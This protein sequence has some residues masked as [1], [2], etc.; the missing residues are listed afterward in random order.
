[1][2]RARVQFRRLDHRIEI[3]AAAT[4]AQVQTDRLDRSL[5]HLYPSQVLRVNLPAATQA[6]VRI[7]RQ[8]QNLVHLYLSLALRVN[9]P[10]A[11]HVQVRIDRQVQ[12]PVALYP[13]QV[14]RVNLLAA[15]RDQARTDLQVQNPVLYHVLV[16]P[17][18]HQAD[19]YRVLRA[20]AAVALPAAVIAHQADP[21]G[22][23]GDNH[24]KGCNYFHFHNGDF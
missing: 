10:A 13:S 17:D 18:V 15:I 3:P 21:R 7:D 20:Q 2:G 19:Q 16:A 11:T 4:Q 14:L 23:V 22:E 12:N 9:L 5:V 24:E 6:Q 8:V 1:M